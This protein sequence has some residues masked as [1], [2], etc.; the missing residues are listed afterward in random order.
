MTDTPTPP[1]VVGPPT[2]RAVFAIN[3]LFPV[4]YPP[5]ITPLIIATQSPHL[6]REAIK[7]LYGWV[8]GKQPLDK[9][10]VDFEWVEETGRE[11]SVGQI[12]VDGQTNIH[13]ALRS[14]YETR[15]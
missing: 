12:N 13:D 3:I 15:E 1:T 4:D 7:D 8:N 6:F 11:H 10:T 2:R 14:V 9:Y 5:P